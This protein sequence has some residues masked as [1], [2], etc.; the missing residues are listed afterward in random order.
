MARNLVSPGQIPLLQKEAREQGELK[1]G[2]KHGK[3]VGQYM[4]LVVPA[5]KDIV[6][7][8]WDTAKHSELINIEDFKRK[9]KN[10]PDFAA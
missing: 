6:N 1:V 9:A 7:E 10:K 3:G 8:I 4:L 2:D 5:F